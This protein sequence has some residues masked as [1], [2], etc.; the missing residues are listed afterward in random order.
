MKSTFFIVTILLSVF[1]FGCGKGNDSPSYKEEII[2]LK[3]NVKLLEK[4]TKD[5]LSSPKKQNNTK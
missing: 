2:K 5:S 1:I 3:S 4:V